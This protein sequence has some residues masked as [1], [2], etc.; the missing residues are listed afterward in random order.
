[1]RNLITL[2]KYLKIK[3]HIFLIFILLILVLNLVAQSFT[4][5]QS[6]SLG[7][8]D[9]Q[10]PGTTTTYNSVP[11]GYVYTVPSPYGSLW[12]VSDEW[13]FAKTP[14][15]F[16]QSVTTVGSNKVWRISNAVT[17]SGYS[18]QPNSP[19]CAL[20]A[21]ETTAA[22][23]ND[24]GL[25]HT[26][27]LSPPNARAIAASQYFHGGFKFRSATGAAQTDLFMSIN[28][29]PRQSNV[30]MSYVGIRDV[31][32]G[33]NLEFYETLAGGAFP[34]SPT[35]IASNLCYTAWYQLDFY[36]EF[37]DGLSG[38]NG[39]DIMK[40]YLNGMLIH[41]GTTW[42][43]YYASPAWTATP[44]PIAVD[45]LMFRLSGTAVPGNSGNGFY[46]DNVSSDN[47]AVP[48]S[49]PVQVYNG[50]ILISGHATITDAINACTTLNGYTI[51]V[52]S[53]TYNEQV[54]VNK[55]V[56][57][58]GVGPGQPT[59]DFTGTPTGKLALFD[60]T[61]NNV[62][63]ENIDFNVDM[64][65]LRS[66]IIASSV[67]LDNIVVKNNNFDPYNTPGG[68]YGDRNAVSINYGGPT[69]YRVADGGVNNIT[70]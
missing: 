6:F 60:I 33:F 70:F 19:S 69:N 17:S 56:T 63:I 44:Y 62:T 55:E 3:K 47:A 1:M 2:T 30:R 31:G 28:A 48:A 7:S 20:P 52:A 53:G 45:A 64:A 34:A 58:I 15:A 43:T 35:I 16:D 39:N 21:G 68:S 66:A 65:K 50:P 67:G 14:P 61:A 49:S 54:I 41:T 32:T 13:G 26:T 24:R 27:P 59:V 18:N 51:N 46:I 5:F 23:Y 40:I 29:A 38:G 22:L 25:N 36:I 4:D 37:V 12:T 9:Y 8:V 57:I 42:E 11:A 10:G